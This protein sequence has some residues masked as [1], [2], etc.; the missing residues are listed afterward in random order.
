MREEG[1]MGPVNSGKNNISALF[2]K[3]NGV[4]NLIETTMGQKRWHTQEGDHLRIRGKGGVGAIDPQGTKGDGFCE[5]QWDWGKK[6]YSLRPECHYVFLK[7]K[8]GV[9]GDGN[10]R[11]REQQPQSTENERINW[12]MVTYVV[13]RMAHVASEPVARNSGQLHRGVLHVRRL[14]QR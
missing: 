2:L 8:E 10:D 11:G 12:T 5:P 3:L 1:N 14:R 7:G 9:R 13:T 4:P 6:C